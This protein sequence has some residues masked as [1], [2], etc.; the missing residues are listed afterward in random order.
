M[1]GDTSPLFIYHKNCFDGFTAAWVFRLLVGEAG[2]WPATYGDKPPQTEG[3]E[4]WIVDFSYPRDEMFA[5][6]AVAKTL[7][8]LDHHKTAEADLFGLKAQLVRFDM[9][10]CGSSLLWDELAPHTPRPWLV[11]Y[12]E[13]RD[14]WRQ[15]LPDTKAV[16]AWI[17]A[18]PMTFEAWDEMQSD[19]RA[20]CASRGA[21]VLRYIEQYG[22]K[23]REQA[24]F[25]TIYGQRVPTMN[26]PY[27]NCSE[28]V[29]ALLEEHPEAEFAAGY[30]RRADGRWQFSLRSKTF[31]VSEV[32]RSFGGGG[33]AGA[34]GFDV[35]RLPW[36][37]RP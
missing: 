34:A 5:I 14:L 32:A 29:G 17:A 25:E 20:E 22:R 4:V 13:D 35:D 10:R 18:Q 23:A 15:A 30:F 3:R 26:L 33:H 24:R 7:Y 31:D 2:W 11:E 16:T 19:G 6:A 8:V 21:A 36:E 9:K 1:K 27:M 37:A 28:H 12:V